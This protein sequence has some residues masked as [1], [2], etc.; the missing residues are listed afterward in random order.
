V[1]TVPTDRYLTLAA[2][3]RLGLCCSRSKAVHGATADMDWVLVPGNGS[4]SP[5]ASG[6]FGSSW[7]PERRKKS[8]A[9]TL[10]GVS[11]ESPLPDTLRKHE[12][13]REVG[14]WVSVLSRSD[15][16]LSTLTGR[17]AEDGLPD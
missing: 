10:V 13:P 2:D 5:T 3:V 9:P 8:V 6:A 12:C 15:S 16:G 17:C 1:H 11:R 14:A 7:K 4:G